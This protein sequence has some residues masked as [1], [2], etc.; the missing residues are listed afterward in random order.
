MPDF[1][2]SDQKTATIPITNHGEAGSFNSALV[3]G[4]WVAY[5]IQYFFLAAGE[6]K[7]ISH[8]I[9]MPLVLGI[10]PVS[11]VVTLEGEE[12]PLAQRQYEDIELLSPVEGLVITGFHYV[13]DGTLFWYISGWIAWGL[14]V[15]HV[16][17][18]FE[19]LTPAPISGIT[20]R[21]TI[22]DTYVY[23]SPL[24]DS[25]E[26][27]AQP[28]TAPANAQIGVWFNGG[29]L[30]WGEPVPNHASALAEV[31]VNGV[32]VATGTIEFDILNL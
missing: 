29:P 12:A 2:A 28:F 10:Y 26:P 8:P 9:T 30:D 6:Q 21:L 22:N 23:N 32:V 20:V 24:N 27:I 25:L 18:K 7:N 15:T 13:V 16:G 11:L 4:N 3:I 1:Q 19:N 31:L 5:S 17:F 14:R